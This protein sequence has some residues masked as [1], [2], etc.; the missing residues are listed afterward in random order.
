MDLRATWI[1]GRHLRAPEAPVMTGPCAICGAPPDGVM[2]GWTRE[3][4]IG[5]AF[6][7]CDV[8]GEGTHVCEYC[9]A[10]LGRGQERQEFLKNFSFLATQSRL[11]LLKREDIWEHLMHPPED[12]PW[13]LGITITHKKH[14]SI[15][16]PVNLPTQRP[17]W[18]GTEQGRVELWPERIPGLIS[19]ITNWYT[20]CRKTGAQSTWFTKDDILHGVTDF[21]KIEIYGVAKWREEDAIIR[22]HRGTDRL[23]LLVH[24]LN[25]GEMR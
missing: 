3:A 25:K 6:M 2:G 17:Y 8:L 13:C 23:A 20:I 4:A 1:I 19:A 5:D 24:A 12:E 10:C 14:I 15:K 21:K 22:C 18:I 16:C 11:V 7:D 9:L